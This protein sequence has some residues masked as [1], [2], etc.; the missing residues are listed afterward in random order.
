[1]SSFR[2]GFIYS[3]ITCLSKGISH[4]SFAVTHKSL[5]MSCFLPIAQAENPFKIKQEAQC[6]IKQCKGPVDVHEPLS[7]WL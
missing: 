4:L 6:G 5:I 1:M 3:D 2:Y 7:D